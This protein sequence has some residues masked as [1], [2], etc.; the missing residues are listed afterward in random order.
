MHSRG[1]DV[2]GKVIVSEETGRK[3][4]VV[5][6]IN[7]ISESGELLNLVLVEPTKH[8]GDLNLEKD[9]NNRLM[10]PFSSV[11]SVGDFVIISEKEIV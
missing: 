9:E 6:D 10:I 2:M 4:G 7:F 3:F 8:I 11:K 1:R 5:G